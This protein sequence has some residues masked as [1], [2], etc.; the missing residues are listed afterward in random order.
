MAAVDPQQT[1]EQAG[2]RVFYDGSCPLCRRE[3]GLYQGLQSRVP[4]DWCDVS[5]PANDLN[6]PER[7]QRCELMQRFHVQTESGELKHGAA[8][9]VHLWT[10]FSGW[11]V[12]ASI[13]KVPGMLWLMEK[14]Y[15]GF[16]KIRPFIQRLARD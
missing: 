3:I 9:F 5:D 6:L 4:V 15:S 1:L 14:A 10:Q 12:L 11:R 8:G 13:A 7:V 16:L 2:I